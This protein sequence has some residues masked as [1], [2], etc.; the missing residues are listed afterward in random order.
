MQKQ[1]VLT[2]AIHQILSG[3][4]INS[5]TLTL[6]ACV[7]GLVN[8]GEMTLAG[9]GRNMP[10]PVD[11]KHKIK[12]VDRFCGNKNVDAGSL[13]GPM[14]LAL[15][16]RFPWL[17]VSVDW[18]K[19]D[20]FQVLVFAV[21]SRYGRAIPVYWEVVDKNEERMKAVE[22][23][24][25][26]RFHA[27]VP[28]RVKV[29]IMADRGFDEV[30]FIAAVARNFE[31][32]IRIAKSNSIS[33]GADLVKVP[34]IFAA[35]SG[36]LTVRDIV[37]DFGDVLFTKANQFK[38][39]VIG[40]H[41]SGKDDPWFLATSL[42]DESP[43]RIVRKYARRFDIEHAFKDWKDVKHGW[44]LGGIRSTSTERLARL[45]IIPAVAFLL[46]MLHG[47]LGESRNLHR[48]LQC[49]SKK[50]KRCLSLWRV[51]VL[52]YTTVQRRLPGLTVESLMN[53]LEILPFQMEVA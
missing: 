52:L 36:Q 18:T 19:I 34:R 25:I 1:R 21:T 14:L 47:L 37:V 11:P 35:L 17:V 23:E 24:A 9:I 31:Y 12:R 3:A 42:K 51:G 29:T 43:Q 45:L 16:K 44:Q 40:L 39:R 27:L 15:S 48:G 7:L 4:Y 33:D 32:V 53:L 46:M 50:D 22:V 28:L 49:N 20:D 10:G 6:V 38:T 13:C 2:M 30:K 8:G 26:D 5:Q 41:K